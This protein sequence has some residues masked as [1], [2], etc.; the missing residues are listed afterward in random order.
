[1]QDNERKSSQKGGS[2]AKAVG[3]YVANMLDPVARARGFAITSL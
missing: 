2:A 1:M 3:A